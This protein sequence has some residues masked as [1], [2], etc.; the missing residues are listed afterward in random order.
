V[1]KGSRVKEGGACGKEREALKGE[2]DV[3]AQRGSV[4]GAPKN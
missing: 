1:T 2:G 3:E 4:A